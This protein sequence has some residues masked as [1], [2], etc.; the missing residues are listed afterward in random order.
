MNISGFL[1]QLIG[2]NVGLLIVAA[3]VTMPIYHAFRLDQITQ[4]RYAWLATFFSLYLVLAAPSYLVFDLLRQPQ[5]EGALQ[6]RRVERGTHLFVEFGCYTCHGPRGEG[7]IGPPLNVA[8]ATDLL[9]RE[10]KAPFLYKTIARGRERAGVVMP[11]WLKEEGGPLDSEEVLALVAFIKDGTR[12]DEVAATVARLPTPTPVTA[13]TPVEAGRL[14]FQNKCSVCHNITGDPKFGPNL[15][16]IF[17]KA[18]LPNG[19]P[20][21]DENMAAW[22]K[23]GTDYTPKPERVMPPLGGQLSAQDLN[24]VIEYLKTLK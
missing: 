12:W 8:F 4:R 22:I 21:N 17:S 23:S 18:Q 3:L 20:V 2:L 19:R 1:W 5:A 10:R 9:A 14:V 6:S 13:K 11:P 16:G 7:G 24:N 15:M